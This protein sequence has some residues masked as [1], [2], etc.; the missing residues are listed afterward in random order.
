MP[1]SMNMT[2]ALTSDRQLEKMKAFICHLNEFQ[3]E[4]NRSA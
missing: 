3:Q 2:A 1:Q 4:P